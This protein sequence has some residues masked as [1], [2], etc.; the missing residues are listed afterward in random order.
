M[1]IDTSSHGRTQGFNSSVCKERCAIS[2]WHCLSS[3]K[4]PVA[5]EM[6]VHHV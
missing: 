2:L 3:G 1:P 4:G 6:L 5:F